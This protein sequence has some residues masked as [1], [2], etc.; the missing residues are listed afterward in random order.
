MQFRIKDRV[1]K[2]VQ[3]SIDYALWILVDDE[4]QDFDHKRKACVYLLTYVDDFLMVGPRH[5]RN[6]IEEEISRIWKVRVEGHVTQFDKSN[7]KA[8]GYS[9]AAEAW[10]IYDEPGSFH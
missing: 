10:R 8:N 6:T 3:S 7:P 1:L 2:A 4:P 9:I 5:V